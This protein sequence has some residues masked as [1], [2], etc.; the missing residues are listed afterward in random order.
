MS[1]TQQAKVLV[2]LDRWKIA[3]VVTPEQPL[4]PS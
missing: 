2:F 1:V 4:E 3:G